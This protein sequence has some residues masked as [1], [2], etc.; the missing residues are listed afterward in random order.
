LDYSESFFN[1][2]FGVLLSASHVHSYTE[3]YDVENGYNRTP[4]TN[5]S[6]ANY[7]PRPLVIRQINFKDGPKYITKDSYLMTM[8][9]KVTPRLVLSLNA[10]YTY[11]EGQ[12]WNRN[13]TFVA[14]NDNNNANNG[15][16]RVGGDGVNTVIATRAASGTINNVATLNNGGGSSSKLTYTRTISPRFEFKLNSWIIDGGI[17]YSRSVNNY[18]SP[19]TTGSTSVVS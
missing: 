18:E 6:A 13:F 3:Q 8:D 4:V 17:N 10:Q 11:T 16:S 12:F 2:R 14:A 1:Q 5:Q 9:W 15:R 7:D 19:E